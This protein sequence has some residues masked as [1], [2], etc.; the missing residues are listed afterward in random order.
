MNVGQDSELVIKATRTVAKTGKSAIVVAAVTIFNAELL[1]HV[2]AGPAGRLAEICIDLW[3]KE[4]LL[5]NTKLA[6]QE[7]LRE[8]GQS[9]LSPGY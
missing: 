5:L 4:A 2:S 3:A 7:K 1:S 9:Q 8:C 6:S